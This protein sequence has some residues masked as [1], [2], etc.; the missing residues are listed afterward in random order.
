MTRRLHRCLVYASVTLA[1]PL[2]TLPAAAQ[3]GAAAQDVSPLM[4]R[5]ISLVQESRSAGPISVDETSSKGLK[6]YTDGQLASVHD[7][8]GAFQILAGGRKGYGYIAAFN[9]DRGEDPSATVESW[10]LARQEA[11][12]AVKTHRPAAR[13]AVRPVKPDGSAGEVQ[14]YGTAL[15]PQC[16]VFSDNPVLYTGYDGGLYI[17]GPAFVSCSAPVDYLSSYAQLWRDDADGNGFYRWGLD[18]HEYDF[19]TTFVSSAA[20]AYCP[21]FSAANYHVESLGYAEWQGQYDSAWDIGWDE[22]FTC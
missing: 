5:A 15:A 10:I 22:F 8:K 6:P 17:D 13:R 14:T 3:V 9:V 4:R 20:L 12:S 2:T 11:S 16:G 18:N 21:G 1:L 19:N 7:S